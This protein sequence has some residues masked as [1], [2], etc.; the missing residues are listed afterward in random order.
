MTSVEFAWNGA[1]GAAY[2]IHCDPDRK[3][4][5]KERLEIERRN[6]MDDIIRALGNI[7]RIDLEIFRL[8][9]E[10]KP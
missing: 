6:A 3:K 5:K 10:V 7:E 2:Y 9:S 1:S 4:T 8:D